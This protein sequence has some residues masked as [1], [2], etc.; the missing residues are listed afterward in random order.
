MGGY[1]VLRGNGIVHLM[2]RFISF[3]RETIRG[4]SHETVR[5]GNRETIRRDNRETRRG[6]QS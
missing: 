3:S 1:A 5:G 6:G 4:D 2:S